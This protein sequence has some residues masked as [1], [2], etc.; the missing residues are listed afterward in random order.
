MQKPRPRWQSWIDDYV[1]FM[2]TDRGLSPSAQS[3]Y[4]HFAERYLAWQFRR[5][6]VDWRRVRPQDIWRYVRRLRRPGRKAQ[7]LN[8]E[9]SALRQFLRFVH[10]RGG[11][12]FA[13]AQAVPAVS[14][15]PRLLE[16]AALT[17]PDRQRLLACF[18]RKSAD[19]RRDYAMALCMTDLGLR[20][21]EIVRLCLRDLDWQYQTMRVPPAKNGRGRLLPLP[22]HVATALRLYVST[23]APT[24]SDRLFVGLGA[25]HGSPV[26][27][28]AVRS[29][30]E[31]AYRRCGLSGHGTH[32]L[33]RSFATRLYARGANLK[34]IADLLGHRLVTTTERY[35]QVDRDGLVALVRPWPL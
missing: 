30:M 21:I 35:A 1:R 25:V 13:L 12:T 20:C 28:S 16:R 34:E 5:R 15:G 17:E 33:R 3:H 22:P 18:D 23:R 19:G 32:C 6:P 4:G 7:G 2:E 14:G 10:L 29:A 31:A 9:L 11:G 27:P 8:S 26:G 24:D